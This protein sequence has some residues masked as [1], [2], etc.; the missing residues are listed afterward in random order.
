MQKIFSFDPEDDPE[1]RITHEVENC[2][3]KTESGDFVRYTG[4]GSLMDGTVFWETAEGDTYNTYLGHRSLIAGM[5]KVRKFG[6]NLT[7][8]VNNILRRRIAGVKGLTENDF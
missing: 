5:E 7:R 1:V 8:K 2:A 3:R 4:K 6:L